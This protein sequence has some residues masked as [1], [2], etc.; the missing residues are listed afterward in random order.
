[1]TTTIDVR[2]A[3]PDDMPE[4][5]RV[6]LA[7][8]AAA[9]RGENACPEGRRHALAV[10]VELGCVL[11]AR[12][13]DDVVGYAAMTDGRLWRELEHGHVHLTCLVLH[14][15]APRRLVVAALHERL[16]VECR[17]RSLPRL[18]MAPSRGDD[19]ALAEAR[20]LGYTETDLPVLMRRLAGCSLLQFEGA[21]RERTVPFAFAER[22]LPGSTRDER[23]AWARAETLPLE[24]PY[25]SWQSRGWLPLYRAASVEVAAVRAAAMIEHPPV[26]RE[27]HHRQEARRHLDDALDFAGRLGVRRVVVLPCWGDDVADGPLERAVEFFDAVADRARSMGCR[28]AVEHASPRLSAAFTSPDD[29]RTLLD[30]LAAPDVFELLVDTGRLLDADV[31]PEDFF[32]RWHRPV[33]VI[34]VT[35]RRDEPPQPPALTDWLDSLGGRPRLVTIGLDRAPV[36]ADFTALVAHVRSHLAPPTSIG[37][38]GFEPT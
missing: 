2:W 4:L 3:T 12:L 14:P 17:K 10:R 33:D 20:S 37:E 26:H 27:R 19:R 8:G 22:A 11:V 34:R 25:E 23:L 35:G 38:A 24:I 7:A 16:V 6:S 21:L 13:A 15:D 5:V 28:L 32:R 9:G 18:T 1:V 31:T 36:V 30:C 29:V